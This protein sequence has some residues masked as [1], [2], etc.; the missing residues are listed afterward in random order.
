M[1]YLRGVV[2]LALLW[3]YRLGRCVLAGFALASLTTPAVAAIL[4]LLCAVFELQWA[5][6]VLAAFALWRLWH[7]PLWAAVLAAAP[8]LLLMLPGLITTGLARWRHPR[9]RWPAP[10][11][12]PLAASRGL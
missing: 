11:P 1:A 2:V 8:R 6:R 5:L 9:A 4:V 7:W 3:L 10:A 12:Q